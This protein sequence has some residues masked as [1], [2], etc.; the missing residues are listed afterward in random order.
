[1]IV[2]VKVMCI[3]SVIPLR[4]EQKDQSEIVSQLLFGEVA[5]I[6][7]KDEQWIKISVHHD[8][9]EGW[10]DSKQVIEIEEQTFDELAQQKSRQAQIVLQLN[11]PWGKTVVFQG[12]PILSSDSSFTVD[13]MKF[14]W[15][16]ETPVESDHSI[17]QIAQSYFNAPYLWGGRTRYGIDC[18]GFTQTVFHQKGIELMRDASQQVKQGEKVDFENIKA[19]DV[20]F[21]ASSKTGNVTHVGIYLGEKSIIHAHGRVRVDELRP[22]GIYNLEKQYLSHEFYAIRRYL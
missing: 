19:G 3:L 5:T 1:M 13:N 6:L 12:S 22:E 17:V 10:I 11:T 15:F 8:S 2:G 21:F 16:N 7:E 4:A 9:Y 20:V 14:S 18:S